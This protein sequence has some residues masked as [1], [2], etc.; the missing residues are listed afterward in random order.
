M[1]H[2]AYNIAVV[3]GSR[4]EFGLLRPLI[5]ELIKNSFRP[6]LLVTGS[7][8]AADSGLTISEIKECGYEITK[9]FDILH[10]SSLTPMDK[11]FSEAVLLFSGF[12]ADTKPDILILL[13]DRY[14]ILASALAAAFNRIP[15]AHISGGDVTEGALD[16][17][18]RHCITKLS[19]LHFTS[20]E[21]YRRRVIQL[22]ESPDRVFNVGALGVENAY[23]LPVMSKD[24]LT[25]SINFDFNSPYILCTYHPETLSDIP[26]EYCVNNLLD[27]LGETGLPV[28][29]TKANV[30]TGGG[31]INSIL[32]DYCNTVMGSVLV[33]NLGSLRYLNAMRYAKVIVGNSSSAI[34]ESPCF[35]VP[36]VNIGD[37][38][39]G[40]IMADNIVG[41]KTD[42]S[43]IKQALQLALSDG[44]KERI[45]ELVN[46]YGGI[47]VSGKILSGIL[48]W[49]NEN[50]KNTVKSF[51]D[52]EFN[53]L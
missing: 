8:L 19:T 4:A 42:S 2:Q 49:L 13:G 41:C 23:K 15:I 40:R 24:E 32:E 5:D 36:A 28:L 30:D 11:A 46:P 22:G 51:Y 35:S 45:K 33:N 7:H 25:D 53:L 37:R 52:V 29:F 18:F 47:D 1:E 17:A 43:S 12:F 21:E 3:T 14:E 20:T 39:K 34:V 48:E 9:C 27:A 6:S 50:R 38:Q 44:F 26:V 10:N 31:V 16:D